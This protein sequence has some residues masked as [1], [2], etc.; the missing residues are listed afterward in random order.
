MSTISV[1]ASV[2]R[3]KRVPKVLRRQATLIRLL[4][5]LGMVAVVALLVAWR[6]F[7]VQQL[8]IDVA[9]QR[10]TMLQLDQEI[11]HLTGSIDTAAPYNEVAQWAFEKHGWKSRTTHIDSINIP[12]TRYSLS[13]S[14]I[15]GATSVHQ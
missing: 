5:F 13:S 1:P 6:N 7:T 10:S 4:S 14:S 3:P 11:Q 8:T 12:V 15:N 2:Y 9:R